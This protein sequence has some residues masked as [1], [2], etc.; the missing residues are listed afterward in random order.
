ML[1]DG[2]AHMDPTPSPGG[3]PAA[4]HGSPA[5]AG[6]QPAPGGPERLLSRV[7]VQGVG[8]LG[9]AVIV[10]SVV[11][12]RAEETHDRLA[13]LESELQLLRH[14][15][16]RMQR[17]SEE[18]SSE[19][20]DVAVEAEIVRWQLAYTEE[21]FARLRDS[22]DHLRAT[23]TRSAASA[24]ASGPSAG[25]PGSEGPS[26]SGPPAYTAGPV[27]RFLSL[28]PT[29][30]LSPDA[31]TAELHLPL[32]SP[33]ARLAMASGGAATGG[34]T[35]ASLF[36]NPL[37]PMALGI[38]H[39]LRQRSSTDPSAPTGSATDASDP[40]SSNPLLVELGAPSA[41]LLELEAFDGAAGPESLAPVHSQLARDRAFATWERI[42]DEAVQGECGH[43]ASAAERKCRDRVARQLFPYAGRAVACMLS[44]N[45]AADYVDDVR[46]DQLP[47]HSVPLDDGAVILCDGGLRNL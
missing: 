12:D 44:G 19:L 34:F 17:L 30:G 28:D 9:V 2:H 26:A 22:T 39:S 14:E 31:R 11:D 43:R 32:P 1:G 25:S 5:P 42:V 37:D 40:R 33:S 45:A 23:A 46:L 18:L 36:S 41:R 16:D 13:T 27:A 15:R 4:P 10:L 21:R 47:T 38:A 3:G 35:D 6:P 8:M 29:H 20:D 24:H 7:L